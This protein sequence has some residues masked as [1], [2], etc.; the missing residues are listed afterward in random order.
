MQRRIP[1]PFNLPPLTLTRLMGVIGA[2]LLCTLGLI[3]DS[4][5]E[6]HWLL[7]ATRYTSCALVFGVVIATYLNKWAAEHHQDLITAALITVSAHLSVAIYLGNVNTSEVIA[8]S[9]FTALNAF[10]FS[11]ARPLVLFMTL[12]SLMMAFAGLIVPDPITPMSD[13]GIL[14]VLGSVFITVLMASGVSAR[15]DRGRSEQITSAVFDQSTDGLLY[16]ELLSG[17][18]LS[19]NVRMRELMETDDEQAIADLLRAAYVRHDPETT[20]RRTMAKLERSEVLVTLELQTATGRHFWGDMAMRSIDVADENIMML[21]V[22][23]VTPRVKVAMKLQQ[24]QILLDRSQS[25]ARVG[26]WEYT[27]STNVWSITDS[28]RHILQVPQEVTS[29]WD[30]LLSSDHTAS[31]AGLQAMHRCITDG[32]HFDLELPLRSYKGRVFTARALGEPIFEKGEVSKV[33]GVFM[34]ISESLEREAQLKKA[35]DAAEAA[36]SARTQ[37]LANMSHEIR[38]PMNGIIG[39]TSLLQNG[40]L[41]TEQEQQVEIIRSS[42]ELLMSIIDEILDFSKID[43]GLMEIENLPFSLEAMLHATTKP[44]A[45]QVTAKNLELEVCWAPNTNPSATYLGDQGRIRQVLGNLLSNAVKFTETG[46]ITLHVAQQR[47]GPHTLLTLAVQDTGIG[48]TPEQADHLFEP[49]RQADSSTTRKYG[50]TGLGLS[51]S[52]QLAQLMGGELTLV[53][54]PGKG[55]QFTLSIQ[56]REVAAPAKRNNSEVVKTFTNHDIK[57]LVVEDNRVN[58]KVAMQILKRLNV[59]GELAGNGQEALDAVQQQDFDVVFMD[60]QMPVL[61]GLEATRQIRQLPE[62]IQP[63]IVAMTANALQEDRTAC[64]E[65]GMDNFISKPV[66]LEDIRDALQAALKHIKASV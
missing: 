28:A 42:G 56:L 13:F 30:G 22:A 53:S 26:G 52:R 36:A 64:L 51:I 45:A 35:R 6:H 37:F 8:A 50:G 34:D 4:L 40:E 61:D 18:V 65:A 12:S 15:V 55:S 21:R 49:F 14:L 10:T 25:M 31:R 58:Q 7:P 16:G 32:E 29:M 17:K 24:T 60:M 48:V 41:E 19:T 27:P 5:V 63:Q 9:V 1:N 39:M 2:G 62:L 3:F 20:N 46:K 47:S 33:V 66:R 54:E 59:H 38:T 23:D 11:R 44:L 43:A 57:V